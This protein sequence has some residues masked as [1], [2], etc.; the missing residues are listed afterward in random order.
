MRFGFPKSPFFGALCAVFAAGCGSSP[1]VSEKTIPLWQHNS[2]A[3]L[4][5]AFAVAPDV[6]WS[7]SQLGVGHFDR[8][9]TAFERAPGIDLTGQSDLFVDQKSQPWIALP[10]GLLTYEQ[11]EWSIKKMGA[12]A[13]GVKAIAENENGQLVVALRGGGL[14]FL[15]DDAFSIQ[16]ERYEINNL[17]SNHQGGI[18]A[19]TQKDG[20]LLINGTEA[21]RYTSDNGLCANQ[22]VNVQAQGDAVIA[23]CPDQKS[24]SIRVNQ[25]WYRYSLR[26]LDHKIDAVA[27]YKDGFLLSIDGTLWK[28][29]KGDAHPT[30]EAKDPVLDP[31]VV[32]HGQFQ[33]DL[34]KNKAR[35]FFA[36]VAGHIANDAN[37]K[38]LSLQVRTSTES[39]GS[40][41]TAP[42][43][44]LKTF[45]LPE[46]LQKQAFTQWT[47]DAN[48]TLWIARPHQGLVAL[49]EEN[50]TKLTTNSL[51][52]ASPY[53]RIVLSPDGLPMVNT[54]TA[55][56]LILYPQGWAK[57]LV[58]PELDTKISALASDRQKSIWAAAIKP[59]P[60]NPEAEKE[61]DGKQRYLLELHRALNSQPFKQVSSIA[62]PVLDGEPAVGNPLALPEGGLLFPFYWLNAGG[63]RQG[64]GALKISTDGK[65]YEHWTTDL[66]GFVDG[67][68]V[69]IEGKPTLPDEMV[70]VLLY[71]GDS[72]YM[73][74]NGG[75]VKI[76][77][78]KMRIYNENDFFD[79]EEII[80][81]AFDNKGMLWIGT[82]EGLGALDKNRWYGAQNKAVLGRINAIAHDSKDRILV[83]KLEG[84]NRFVKDRWLTIR[85]PTGIEL[86]DVRDIVFQA[87]GT[88][89]LLTPK[90][91]THA[92][93][94][95]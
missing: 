80:S 56:I 68:E 50:L 53:D 82:P 79:S 58:T 41:E 74:T 26:N 66:G 44:S 92:S 6:V 17:S 60:K 86:T 20:L 81:L 3:E 35:S 27:P 65:T 36:R 54:N 69:K 87:D 73:G 62:L 90:G 30:K 49:E 61:S 57:R 91:L 52:P 25:H 34:S 28:M 15:K 85:P 83:G 45:E 39:V 29:A 77:G 11:K 63:E 24:V 38:P 22:I 95:L 14:G 75:L 7:T 43:F 10:S 84:L 21:V 88:L 37:Y 40:A 42:P 23:L 59:V 64:A 78:N 8:T 9:T 1:V 4:I 94:K 32:V 76:T 70:N 16:T 31:M 12:L 18:W 19:S 51:V 67:G 48:G 2:D 46:E 72:I 13:R 93:S 47:V 71:H 89:W 33:D 5:E 55:E